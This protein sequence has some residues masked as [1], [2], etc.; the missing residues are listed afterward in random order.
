MLKH[1]FESL[2][3][4]VAAAAAVSAGSAP[5]AQLIRLDHGEGH[6]D[7]L[8]ECTLPLRAQGVP[9][10]TDQPGVDRDAVHQALGGEIE[11]FLAAQLRP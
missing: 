4:F 1:L 3:L 8:D 10:C 6:F 11:R 2:V 9:L 7:N 5:Q